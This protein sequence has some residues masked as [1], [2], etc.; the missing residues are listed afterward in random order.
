MMQ[1]LFSLLQLPLHLLPL[2]LLCSSLT[3]PTSIVSRFYVALRLCAPPI[4]A[5][6]LVLRPSRA[7]SLAAQSD[8]AHDMALSRPPPPRTCTLSAGPAAHPPHVSM[9][10]NFDGKAL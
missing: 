2:L 5:P 6:L 10:G 7:S 4:A 9:G 1:I 8:V 3:R